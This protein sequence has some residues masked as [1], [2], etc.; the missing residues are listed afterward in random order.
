MATSAHR[1]FKGRQEN[2]K[3]APRKGAAAREPP[4]LR[5]RETEPLR[6]TRPLCPHPNP[7]LSPLGQSNSRPCRAFPSGSRPASAPPGA[8]RVSESKN[9]LRLF[10]APRRLGRC[11][12]ARIQARAVM[13][14]ASRRAGGPV[15]RGGGGAR[16]CRGSAP[17]AW[18]SESCAALVSRR[19][20]ARESRP[21]HGRV[22][23][24]DRQCVRRD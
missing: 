18:R 13:R 7:S 15:T 4:P 2:V 14:R 19:Q 5:R 6:P 9:R 11:R 22:T 24:S 17:A 12:P 23:G 8:R 21:S 1:A 20:H 10:Q 3:R 16:P